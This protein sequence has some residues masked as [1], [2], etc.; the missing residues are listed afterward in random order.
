MHNDV[1]T[2]TTTLL[3]CA[4]SFCGS[5]AKGVKQ[6]QFNGFS[7]LF[8][9]ICVSHFGFRALPH[10]SCH[11]SPLYLHSLTQA[12]IPLFLHRP[13][14]ILRVSLNWYTISARR[15]PIANC[16][17]QVLAKGC[18]LR[19]IVQAQHNLVWAQG[20][21]AASVFPV[22]LSMWGTWKKPYRVPIPH[23]PKML[24]PVAEGECPHK[25]E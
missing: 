3:K 5:E 6:L 25:R 16:L 14:H 4:Y 24:Q 12:H 9:W 1:L 2:H 13:S 8:S 10:I 17:L 20:S 21:K 18:L 15:L 22:A 19:Q 23:I 7:S 11:L